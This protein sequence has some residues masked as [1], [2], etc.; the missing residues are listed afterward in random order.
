ARQC[1]ETADQLLDKFHLTKWASAS[2][3]ALS[4]GMAQRLM[5]A[6]SILHRPA[7]LFMDEP[8]HGLD[9]QSRLA[10]WDI[11]GELN[12]DGQTITLLT[13]HMEEVQHVWD[14]VALIE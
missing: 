6:R 4:G 3:Y 14:G 7:V 8:T 11:L 5:V 2:V 1:R 10:L 12:R 9:P 13:D